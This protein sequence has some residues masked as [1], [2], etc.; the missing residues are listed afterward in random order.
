MCKKSGCSICN[1]DHGK[2]K[3]QEYSCKIH[4][5]RY[6]TKSS[7]LWSNHWSKVGTCGQITPSFFVCSSIFWGSLKQIGLLLQCYCYQYVAIN[8]SASLVMLYELGGKRWTSTSYGLRQS[9]NRGS[10]EITGI[11]LLIMCFDSFKF[12][13]LL[14]QVI[15]MDFFSSQI[16]SVFSEHTA[17]SSVFFFF[18]FQ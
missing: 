3:T 7:Y 18:F 9:I 10:S 2:Y 13:S 17:I 5:R 8:P 4:Y 15:V 14:S 12:F 1:V 11:N 16:Q 6:K